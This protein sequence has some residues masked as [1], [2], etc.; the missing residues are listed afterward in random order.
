MRT[1]LDILGVTYTKAKEAR[2][3]MFKVMRMQ[4]EDMQ[5]RQSYDV[6]KIQGFAETQQRTTAILT[7]MQTDLSSEF[8]PHTAYVVRKTASRSIAGSCPLLP[9]KPLVCVFIPCC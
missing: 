4:L 6:R 2:E 3:F 9:S 7:E 8:T 5:A 1:E